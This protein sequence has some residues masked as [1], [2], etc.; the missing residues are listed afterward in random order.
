[1][2]HV[3]VTDTLQLAGFLF[4]GWLLFRFTDWIYR[5]RL[6]DDHEQHGPRDREQLPEDDRPARPAAHR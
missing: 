5:E 4:G 2:A 3:L 1:M 6:E